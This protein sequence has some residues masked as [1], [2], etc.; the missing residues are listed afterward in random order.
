MIAMA[1]PT[2]DEKLQLVADEL[3][4][5][6]PDVLQY[7]AANWFEEFLEPLGY[8]RSDQSDVSHALRLLC[9][10]GRIKKESVWT[11]LKSGYHGRRRED[12]V[13]PREILI[14]KTGH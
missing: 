9:K 6:L 14:E 7:I 12:Y 10:Q 13:R 11:K 8:T 5:R 2:A 3:Y 4:E 1:P